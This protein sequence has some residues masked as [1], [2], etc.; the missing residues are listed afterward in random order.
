MFRS[1]K[2]TPSIIIIIGFIRHLKSASFIPKK[3]ILRIDFG[4]IDKKKIMHK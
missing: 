2:I 1:A 4:N 3:D